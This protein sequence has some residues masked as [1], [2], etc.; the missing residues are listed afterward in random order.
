MAPVVAAT[1][2]NVAFIILHAGPAVSPRVQARHELENTYPARGF[3]PDEIKEAVAY[4]SLNLDAMNSDEAYDKY[5]AAYEQLKARGVRWLWRPATKEQMRA[6]WIR[7]NVDFD[8]VPVLEKVKCPV[9]AFFGEKDVLVPPEGNVS[10]MEVALKK[11]GNKDVTIK[12]LPAVGHMLSLP[13]GETP[14]GYYDV[15]I[16]WLKRRGIAR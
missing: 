15:M 10:I 5:Q 1:T 2:P 6:R 14:P 3:S 9:I 4:Q 12:V 16:E 13:S 11:A 7:P 8:P